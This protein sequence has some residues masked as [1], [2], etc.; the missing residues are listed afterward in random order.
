M[1][2]WVCAAGGTLL[3]PSGPEG[4]H[5]HII[6]NNPKDF[7]SFPPQSC[8]SVSICTIRKGPYDNT[9][10]INPGPGTHPFIKAPSYV[11]Y[12]YSRIDSATR[13]QELVRTMLFNPL[14]D[15]N[16]NLLEEIRTGLNDS[17]HTPN[18][19]KQLDLS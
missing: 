3:V 7:D 17:P 19:L 2:A 1:S 14:D 16:Q 18:F 4:N 13:L 9:R 8:V 11:A 10:I 6:L 12:R 15:I 5:L